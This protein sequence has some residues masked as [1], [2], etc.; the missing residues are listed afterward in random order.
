MN[1]L[2]AVQD[3]VQAVPLQS[4]R[5]PISLDI[6]LLLGFVALL[7]WWQLLKWADYKNAMDTYLTDLNQHIVDNCNCT[8]PGPGAPPAPPAWPG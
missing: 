7:L 3:V 2:L 5:F 8:S 4:V 6:C 1:M